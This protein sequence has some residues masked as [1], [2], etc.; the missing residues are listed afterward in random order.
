[1]DIES[2]LIGYLIGENKYELERSELVY[3]L[4][5]I[6]KIPVPRT[7]SV[8]QASKF[9]AMIELNAAYNIKLSCKLNIKQDYHNVLCY[10]R[11]NILCKQASHNI[12]TLLNISTDYRDIN[13]EDKIDVICKSNTKNKLETLRISDDFINDIKLD[14][15]VSVQLIKK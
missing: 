11:V 3:T 14:S 4:R 5:D 7:A 13:V 9:L 10:D 8:S 15:N 6:H 2:L 12:H 1:M